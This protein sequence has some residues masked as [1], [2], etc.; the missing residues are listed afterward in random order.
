MKILWFEVTE[1]AGYRNTGEFIGGWQD[2]LEIQIRKRTDIELFVAF[3]S[4]YEHTPIVKDRVTYIPIPTNLSF[5]EHIK[6]LFTCSVEEKKLVPQALSVIKKI[7]PDVIHVFGVE[8]CWGLVAAYVNIPVVIHIMGSMIPYYNAIYPPNYNSFTVL[9]YL[10]PQIRP[11][12]HFFSD[13]YYQRSRVKNEKRIW[14]TV[15]NYMGRTK[16]DFALSKILAPNSNYFHVNE[17]L[18]ESFL[19]PDIQWTPPQSKIRLVSTGCSSFWKGPD[20]FLKTAKLLK[21]YGLDFEWNIAGNINKSIKKV[22]EKKEKCSLESCNIKI[23]GFISPIELVKLLSSSTLYIHTAYIE[24][25]PNSICEAQCVGIPVISTNVGGIS[26]LVSDNVDGLLVPANDPWQ[27]AYSIIEL[28]S[29]MDKMKE[30]SNKARIKALER[31]NPYLI[32]KELLS[33]YSQLINVTIK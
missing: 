16:W 5:V 27:L 33:C 20:M 13:Y 19:S 30:F 15:N 9:K 11:L 32:E 21:E 18:R 4:K 10:F 28:V 26:T 6:S 2:S 12:F 3:S 31:H 23:L 7:N 22:V 24:N 29:N 17:A 25:S 14:K 1:P 8:W